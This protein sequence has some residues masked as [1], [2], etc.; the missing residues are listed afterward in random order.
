MSTF[1]WI[2]RDWHKLDY[3]EDWV[4]LRYGFG[5]TQMVHMQTDWANDLEGAEVS[6]CELLHRV[7]GT[8][9]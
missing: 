6:V 3:M 1:D 9:V 4:N 5:K 2:R 8:N 7:S